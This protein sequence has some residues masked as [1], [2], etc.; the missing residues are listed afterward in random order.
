[1]LVT[2]VYLPPFLWWCIIYVLVS[3]AM[4]ILKVLNVLGP[5]ETPKVEES[6]APESRAAEED[7]TTPVPAAEETPAAPVEESKEVATESKDLPVETKEE[8]PAGKYNLNWKWISKVSL[9]LK[10]PGF[11]CHS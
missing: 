2:C 5:A 6:I 7:V 10:V 1:M 11:G 9:F 3:C 8:I 4:D